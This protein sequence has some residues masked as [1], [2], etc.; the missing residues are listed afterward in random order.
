MAKKVTDKKDN[1]E[2]ENLQEGLT[3]SVQTIDLDKISTSPFNHRKH[4][5]AEKIEELAVSIKEQGLIQPIVLRLK[6][7][8]KT[9]YQIVVGERR[10][11]ASK[12]AGLTTIN[13]IVRDLNDYQAQVLTITENLLRED[14][15]PIEEAHGFQMALVAKSKVNSES[16]TEETESQSTAQLARDLGYSR[17]KIANSIRLLNLEVSIQDKIAKGEINKTIGRN[18]AAQP[19]DVQLQIFK[20]IADKKISVTVETVLAELEI[21]DPEKAAKAKAKEEAK[22]KKIAAEKKLEENAMRAKIEKEN[23][24]KEKVQ[25]L[26]QK[27]REERKSVK[28]EE[29][30]SEVAASV[31]EVITD[32]EKIVLTKELEETK[33][34]TAPDVTKLVSGAVIDNNFKINL[35]IKRLEKLLGVPVSMNSNYDI[36]IAPNVVER[37]AEVVTILVDNLKKVK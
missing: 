9:E 12:K 7:S 34:I 24:A 5:D 27:E 25:T 19:H 21:L 26:A 3:R 36:V 15:T 35:Q 16:K 30:L 1:K 8:G 2:R 10:Y 18:I 33:T 14:P 29:V 20:N 17:E 32:E 22:A 37:A 28:E 13:A 31:D 4:M 6:K 11:V 23:K